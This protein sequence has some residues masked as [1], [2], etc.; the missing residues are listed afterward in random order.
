MTYLMK[1]NVK[2]PSTFNDTSLSRFL[3]SIDLSYQFSLPEC[4]ATSFQ[5][6]SE[7]QTAFGNEVELV[8]FINNGT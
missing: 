7:N 2:Q 8:Y 6:K 3:K 1:I 4:H 5:D